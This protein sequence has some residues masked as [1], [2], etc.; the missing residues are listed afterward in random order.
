MYLESME[1]HFWFGP[2]VI[3]FAVFVGFD[4]SLDFS[5]H[6]NIEMIKDEDLYNDSNNKT[7]YLS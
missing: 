5:A 7:L 2:M 4:C 1:W 3:F 6:I